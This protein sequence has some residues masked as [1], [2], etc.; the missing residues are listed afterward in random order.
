MSTKKQ[1]KA[2]A[3][4]VVAVLKEAGFRLDPEYSGDARYVR[5]TEAGVLSVSTWPDDD[6]DAIFMRWHEPKRAAEV[7]GLGGYGFN[8]YSGKWNIHE[9]TASRALDT[10]RERL[11]RVLDA[12]LAHG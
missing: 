5:E 11:A 7:Y 9:A 1:R 6:C 12:E 4:A 3:D 10:L 2:A 8:P